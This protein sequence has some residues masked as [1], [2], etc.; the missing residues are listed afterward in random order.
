MG[1]LNLIK[2]QKEAFKDA[3]VER[4]KQI[5]LR[6]ADEL[7]A[8]KVR[9]GQLAI[10]EAKLL[11]E[12]RDLE[13][14]QAFN[15]KVQGPSKVE[16]FGKN[17]AVLMSKGKEMKSKAQSQG[18]MKGINFGSPPSTGSKGLETSTKGSP[19][20]SQKDLDFGGQGLQLGKPQLEKKEP[21]PTIIIKT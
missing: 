6:Q 17:L 18:H 2:Q 11:Q 9:Q 8:E 7:H 13:R 10:A 14:I 5:A 19:F 21:R 3:T 12:Q 15:K 16:K 20:G 1:I 4:R